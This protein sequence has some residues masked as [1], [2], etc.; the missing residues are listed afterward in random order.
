MRI[1]FRRGLTITAA[2]FLLGFHVS[3]A[4]QATGNIAGIVTDDSG[5]V[6]PGVTIEVTNTNTGQT[7]GAVTRADG[8]FSLPLLQPGVYQIK[9][10]LSGFKTF[11]REG[12]T[13]TVESTARVDMQLPVGGLQES[14][15]VQADAPLVE[16]SNATL[17]IV[18]DEKKVVELP[19]NGR[20]FTQLGTL[21]PGVV[22]PPAALGGAS[23][24]ATPGGFGATTSGFSVNG[25]R[26]QSNNFLL[27]GASNNDTFNTGFVL[28]PPPDAIQEFKILTHSY[29]AEYGRSAGSV[30]N[31][32]SKGGTNQLHGAVWEF[33]RDDSL[34]ARNY[35]VPSTQPKPKL[36]QNQFGFSL[37]GPVMRNRLFGFGYYE[38]FR[39]TSGVT[40]NFIVL[41]DAQRTGA[42]GATV[43]RDPLTGL[44]FPN[45]QIPADRIDPAALKML[46]LI[47][48]PNLAA[49]PSNYS[50]TGTYE[51]DRDNLDFKVNYNPGTRGSIFARYSIS[52]SDIFDPPSLG[53]AGGDALAGGQPGRAPGRIQST[54]VGAT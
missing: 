23:G 40:Q 17:G 46:L 45:N 38:G 2:L 10:T 21:L 50:A 7:R 3:L 9:G 47:P 13:V 37:G 20:N 41:T 48:A 25:M 31:V 43:I 19:L 5:A 28:R 33:N 16:T 49:F 35:F 1:I 18:V 22:A 42:F 54:A 15:T 24:E 30:V 4:A 6:L 53:D 34:Q 14:I 27:D 11:V 8:Y 12:V 32:V 36:K 52:P 39:N 51:F 44:P 29:T 26:N